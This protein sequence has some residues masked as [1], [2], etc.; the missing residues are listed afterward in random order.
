MANRNPQL[1][2]SAIIGRIPFLKEKTLSLYSRYLSDNKFVGVNRET[3]NEEILTAYEM[4]SPVGMVLN[5]AT[6]S[7]GDGF[8]EDDWVALGMVLRG[9]KEIEGINLMHL[10]NCFYRSSGRY[11]YGKM[12][13]GRVYTLYTSTQFN[14][15]LSI[16]LDD[17]TCKLC[18]TYLEDGTLKIWISEEEIKIDPTGAV[19]KDE[20]LTEE[21]VGESED[22]S[23]EELTTE[24]EYTT[25]SPADSIVLAP[26]Q[27]DNPLKLIIENIE[28][29]AEGI[30]VDVTLEFKTSTHHQASLFE[31]EYSGL[32]INDLFRKNKT[33]EEI[34]L[35]PETL[36]EGTYSNKL[37]EFFAGTLI[38]PD[39]NPTLL[40]NLKSEVQV[41][42]LDTGYTFWEWVLVNTPG[43]FNKDGYLDRR[44][45][46]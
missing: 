29:R 16:S 12:V 14:P 32:I 45:D 31:G 41:D 4:W 40:E 43:C 21:S 20:D 26:I 17:G 5:Q 25:L 19:V 1:I 9:Y 2:K 36:K 38:T 33:P 28:G 27:L 8:T 13:T 39:S 35:I 10:Y 23:S 30:L 7:T 42:L 44:I 34:V 3:K 24:E 22:L 6:I 11:S 15:S 18:Y 46:L 37:V